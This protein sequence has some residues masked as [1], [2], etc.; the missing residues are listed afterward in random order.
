MPST[1]V[2]WSSLC[3][4]ISRTLGT[5][6]NQSKLAEMDR[7][8]VCIHTFVWLICSIYNTCVCSSMT[9]STHVC[10]FHHCYS[11]MPRCG[12]I[13]LY[14]RTESCF[15]GND[16]A[17]AQCMFIMYIIICWLM[18][19]HLYIQRSFTMYIMCSFVHIHVCLHGR[20]ITVGYYTLLDQFTCN[21]THL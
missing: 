1:E 7:C 8:V 13:S 20:Y 19:I 16:L 21:H 18:S 6:T 5:T 9:V 3:V 11:L 17:M 4:W 15:V 10:S 12:S 14:T 2:L